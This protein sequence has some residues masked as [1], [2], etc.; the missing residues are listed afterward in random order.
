MRSGIRIKQLYHSEPHILNGIM[1]NH[2]VSRERQVNGLVW[3]LNKV[4]LKEVFMLRTESME[5][6]KINFIWRNVIKRL[7]TFLVPIEERPMNK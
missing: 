2:R 6:I 1:P 3:N 5:V 7:S 4:C